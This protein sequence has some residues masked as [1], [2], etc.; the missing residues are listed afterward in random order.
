MALKFGAKMENQN[1]G[2]FPPSKEFQHNESF[3]VQHLKV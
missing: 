3:A 2:G 1:G